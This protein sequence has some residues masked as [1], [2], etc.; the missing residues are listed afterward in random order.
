ML[1][2]L[3]EQELDLSKLSTLVILPACGSQDNPGNQEASYN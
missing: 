2:A 1:D 3:V